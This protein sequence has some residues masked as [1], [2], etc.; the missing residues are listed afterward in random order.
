MRPRVIASYKSFPMLWPWSSLQCHKVTTNNTE[1]KKVNY[2]HH[3]YLQLPCMVV[4][5]GRVVVVVVVINPPYLS[6]SL[7]RA[8]ES[9]L[10]P[11][12]TETVV[13]CNDILN[14]GF[15]NRRGIEGFRLKV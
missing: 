4:R 11:S 15:Q 5:Q 8:K 14:F 3:N 2:N 6:I 1:S 7:N 10:Q 13:V 12:T 9:K